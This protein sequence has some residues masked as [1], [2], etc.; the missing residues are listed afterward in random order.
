MRTGIKKAAVIGAGW[1]GLAAATALHEAGA[2]VTVFE[3]GRT[4]GGRARRVVQPGFDTLLDNGQ[5]ILLGAYTETLALMRRLGRNPDTPLMRRPLR[6]AG[7]DGRF[8]LSAPTLP[9]PWHG[10]AAILAARGLSWRDKFAA[11][12]FVRSL[13]AGNWNP[14]AVWTV[15]ELLRFRHQPDNLVE[16]L[17]T[18]LCLAALNT[19]PEEASAALFARVLEGTLAGGLRDSDLLLPCVDLSALWPDTATLQLTM[20]YH[21]TVRQLRIDEH[22]V[23]INNG[24]RF[25][26]AVLAVPPTIVTRLIEPALEAHGAGAQPLLQA[27]RSF[28]YQPIATLNLKLAQPWSLPEPMMM[29]REDRERSHLGQWLFD[30]SRLS[31]RSAKAE[32]AVVASAARALAGMSKE[33]AMAALIEQVRE[34]ARAGGLPAMPAVEQSELFIE[35]RATFTA[36][37]RQPRPQNATPWP[38][39]TLAGDWTDTGY[40]AVLEG[41]V[42]SGL[43]AA[44][45]LLEEY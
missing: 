39:L 29:L 36:R 42:R 9:S 21:N 22:S 23:I 30:R 4:P 28:D 37:P 6:L 34:Q 18:P 33:A 5:H 40:P 10:A 25:E 41:A 27:L 14:P 15:A 43:H 12:R 45:V 32:L 24:E 13:Q 11:M 17:W 26:A 1:A 16:K 35:K 8:R 7:L 3:A 38:A 31:G 2:H 44:K 19:P 20:R